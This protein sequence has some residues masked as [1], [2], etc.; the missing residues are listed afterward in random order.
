MEPAGR[1]AVRLDSHVDYE[2]K[3]H[4]QGSDP[5]MEQDP[6][7]LPYHILSCLLSVEMLKPKNKFS[8]RSEKMQK[9]E[10]TVKGDQIILK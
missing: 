10:N 5:E 2:N 8:Q 1:E 6:L 4:P 3:R 9:E 7:L